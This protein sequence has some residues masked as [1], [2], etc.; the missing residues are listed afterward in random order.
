METEL[1]VKLLSNKQCGIVRGLIRAEVRTQ[2]GY[3]K[4]RSMNTPN[5]KQRITELEDIYD[6]LL[7]KDTNGHEGD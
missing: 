4:N 1:L 3:L 7:V 2:R 6:I 5:I